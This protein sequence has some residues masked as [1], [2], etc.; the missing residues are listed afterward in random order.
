MKVS[1]IA[2][3]EASPSSFSVK[4]P[5]WATRQTTFFHFLS[6]RALAYLMGIYGN[7]S[8]SFVPAVRMMRDCFCAFGLGIFSY[9]DIF[10]VS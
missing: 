4:C 7:T 1:I 5:S 2:R 3:S 6:L 9:G 10:C 8:V